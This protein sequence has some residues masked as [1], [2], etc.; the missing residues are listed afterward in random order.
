MRYHIN[1]YWPD[2]TLADSA[3]YATQA[4][5]E[6][7]LANEEARDMEAYSKA[8]EEYERE[9]RDFIFEADER[10]TEPVPPATPVTNPLKF[11][12]KVEP[13]DGVKCIACYFA[14]YN[15]GVTNWA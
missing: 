1:T 6:A 5:A 15:D 14:G 2:G 3:S 8:M 7:V 10:D 13:C 4:I 11:K 9:L 12:H